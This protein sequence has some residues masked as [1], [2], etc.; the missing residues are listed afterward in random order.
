VILPPHEFTT[1]CPYTEFNGTTEQD[2]ALY[3]TGL[4]ESL[5]RCNLKQEQEAEWFKKLQA[6]LEE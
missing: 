6:D 5:D 1:V 4:K 2:L 3:V